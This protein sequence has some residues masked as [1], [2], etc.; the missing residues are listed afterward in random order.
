MKEKRIYGD[1]LRTLAMNVCTYVVVAATMVEQWRDRTP[2]DFV[3]AAKVPMAITHERVLADAEDDLKA[4]LKVMEVLGGKLGP[5]LFQFP[6]F[7]RQKFRRIGFFLERLEPFLK[8]LSKDHQWVVEVR[9]KNWLSEKLYSVLRK[10]RTALALVDHAWVPRPKEVVE[11]G[12][13]ITTD[14]TFVCWIGDRKGIEEET[15]IWNRTIIDRTEDLQDWRDVLRDLSRRVRVNYGYANNH[16]AGF[17]PETVERFRKL[18]NALAG[19]APGQER[20]TKTPGGKTLPL[21]PKS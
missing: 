21:F 12:D 15:K 17:A 1:F 19:E 13:P 10:H 11:T 6:Y 20:A 4:F 5:L 18:W 14:F 9:N 8:K 7:N 16:Y 3:F 2:A